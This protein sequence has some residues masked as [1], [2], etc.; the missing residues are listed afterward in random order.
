M[1]RP[2]M[3]STYERGVLTCRKCGSPIYVHKL[4]AL[5]DEISVRCN[6]CGDR[7]IYPKRAL[8]IQSMPERRKKPRR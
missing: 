4:N 8:A 2:K 7:G 1:F 3:K 5:A 6:R